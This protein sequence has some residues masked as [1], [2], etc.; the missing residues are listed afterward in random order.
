[1]WLEPLSGDRKPFLFFQTPFTEAFGRF[2]PDG[3]WIAYVSNESGRNDVY[4]APFP[5]PGGA[6]AAATASTMAGKWQISTA[7]GAWPRWRRDGREIF[8]ERTGFRLRGRRYAAAVPHT[9]DR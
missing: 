3:H 4:V 2:S 5:G 6:P 8:C 1:M 7:G 9:R